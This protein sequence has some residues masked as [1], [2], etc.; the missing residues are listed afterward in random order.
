MRRKDR[1]VKD[2]DEILD[3]LSR[4]RVLH[5]AVISGGKPYSVPVNFGYIVTGDTGERK[6]SVFFHGAG[7]GKKLDAIRENPA[8]SFCAEAFADV[9]GNDEACSWTCFYES[10]I[11]FGNA[12]ILDDRKEK[13]QGLDAIMLHNGYKIPS[14]IKEIAYSAMYLAKTAVVKIEVCGITGKRHLKK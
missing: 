7:E 3:I 11:G 6:L 9:S 2:F 8:V 4:S 5:L 12:A 14:G 1:E 10:I 13:A